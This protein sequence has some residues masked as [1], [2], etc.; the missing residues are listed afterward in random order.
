MEMAGQMFAVE[1]LQQL[2]YDLLH[3]SFSEEK[4][5]DA[6]AET[7]QGRRLA[8]IT[9][10]QGRIQRST[11]RI[12]DDL[13][14]LA[15]KNHMISE[16]LLKDLRD[17]VELLERSVDEL[18][19][20]RARRSHETATTT[21]GRMNKV[22]MSLLTAAQGAGGKG[23]GG[24]PSP[25]MPSQQM[26]QMSE[27]QSRLNRMTEELRQKMEGGLTPEERRQLAELRARQE[28]LRQQ[29]NEVRQ[30]IEDERR[31]LGDL[32][33]LAQEMEEVVEDLDSG[34]LTAETRRRQEKI[35][36]RLLDAQRSIRERDFAKRRE[37]RQG[38]DLFLPQDGTPLAAG[39]PDAEQ[40]LRRWLAPERAPHAY[41]DDVRQYFRL[42]QEMLEEDRP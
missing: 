38:E 22:V 16:K 17:L 6:L 3:L 12:S 36:S 39:T 20:S 30:Q 25:F 42:I 15:R 29:L 14:E 8:P 7:A 5:V 23:A 27:D 2:A 34:R 1:R 11:A 37:S 4:I 40:Q 31:V 26:Q 28:A 32:G 24:M 18:Q 33:E 21:M 19:L 10:E 41:Q 9:R 13:Q 35:L